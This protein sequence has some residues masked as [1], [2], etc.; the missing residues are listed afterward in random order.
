MLGEDCYEAVRPDPELSLGDAKGEAEPRPLRRASRPGLGARRRGQIVG[1]V[2]F[3]LFPE[4]GYGHIDNNGVDPTRVGEGWATL[5]VPRRAR[6]LPRAR[7]G[8]RAR[9]HRIGR[10]AHP[11]RRAY[12]AVGFDRQVPRRRPLATAVME[13]GRQHYNVTLAILTLAGTAF[14]L[15][16]T[17]VFPALGT[18]QEEFGA[19]TAWTTW[20]LTGF[21]VS[22]SGADTDPRQAGRPVRE[23]TATADQPWAL[24][25]RLPGRGGRV[26]HLVADRIPH[27]LGRRRCAL[28]AQLRDHPRRVPGREG[29]GRYRPPLGRVRRRRRLRD[30]PLRCDRRQLLVAAALRVR[31][32]PGRDLTRAR[33]PLRPRVADPVSLSRR[34]PGRAAALRR[35]PLV[36]GG[37]DR[38]RSVGLDLA[39]RARA[40]RRGCRVLRPLGTR[41][42]ALERADGG[43]ENA[44][45]PPGAADEHRDDDLGLCALQL[46][47]AHPHLRRDVVRARLRLRSERDA[48]RPVPTPELDRDALCRAWQERSGGTS[49]RSGHSPAAC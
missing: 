38:G 7:P 45:A 30:R 12:E 48:G 6:A 5:H 25:R 34:H 47:R 8:L 49:A 31:R 46:L 37:A 43:H 33:A 42:A 4:R 15:Q 27:R 19:S 26:G 20:V 41:R 36:D 3:W 13:N 32:R 17:M 21:L 28:P 9:R 1:F 23:G 22:G 29:Q 35:P 10:R 18:F 2:T 24:L 16:Q 11:A 14:A 44:V 40:R 39:A